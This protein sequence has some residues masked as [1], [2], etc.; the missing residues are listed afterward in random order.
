MN[1]SDY[2]QLTLEEIAEGIKKADATYK[3]MGAGGVLAETGMYIEG[4]PYVKHKGISEKHDK[5]KPII[6]VGFKVSV[7]HEETKEIDGKMSA[8]IKV[9]SAGK[10]ESGR[11][12]THS[13]NE[14]TFSVPLLYPSERS[15]THKEPSSCQ[16]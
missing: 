16:D 9:F 14:V 11:E 5:Y 1:L 7:I 10:E 3:S 12:V 8:S 13:L 2:I 6:N 15:S 4:I